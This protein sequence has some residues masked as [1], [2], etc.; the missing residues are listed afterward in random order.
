[1]DFELFMYLLYGWMALAVITFL[2]LFKIV[3][4]F[5]RHTSNRFGPTINN[6]LGWMLMEVPSLLS[7]SYFYWTG[8]LS[9]NWVTGTMYGLWCAH[10]INRSFIY[11]FRQKNKRKRM[12]LLIVS[13]AVFFNVMNGFFNGYYLGHFADYA[14]DWFWSAPFFVGSVLFVAGAAI[15]IDADNRLLNL[16][17][18]GENGYKIPRG[19]LFRRISC[20]NLFGEKLEWIGFA[21]LCWN[22]AA[23]S[24]A[25]WTWANLL[26]RALA[27]HR[28]YHEKFD[29]YPKS[30]KAVIPFVL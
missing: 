20:P 3:A 5:G 7:I 1:M 26:P 10:Y 28:W 13:S 2:A 18:P 29:D 23:F 11:P 8:P 14:M 6:N 22:P 9:P 12:P 24:F 15:N 4:P 25:L 21:V 19:G 17:K 27:H 16:R 30:R